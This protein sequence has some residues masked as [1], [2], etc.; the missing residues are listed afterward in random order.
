MEIAKILCLLINFPGDT[1]QN[2]KENSKYNDSSQTFMMST[3]FS[4][5]DFGRLVECLDN[6][7]IGFVSRTTYVLFEIVT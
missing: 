7:F 6:L 3:N 2:S 4:D 5:K 1:R